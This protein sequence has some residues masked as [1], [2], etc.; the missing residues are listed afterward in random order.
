LKRIFKVGVTV[1]LTALLTAPVAYAWTADYYWP[2]TRGQT[3]QITY[4]WGDRLDDVPNSVWRKVFTNGMNQ[5]TTKTGN[6]VRFSESSS[7]S[8]ILNTYDDD[9]GN[10]GICYRWTHWLTGKLT[11]FEAY[12][13]VNTTAGV[14]DTFRQSVATHELGHGLGLGHSDQVAVMNTD[15]DRNRIYVPQTDD[16]N[17]ILSMYP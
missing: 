5:W 7:S 13:N 6:K 11:K 10:Y 2:H 8:N 12:G 4:K 3:L 9:D 17:G 1:T 15:R 16:V 14:S